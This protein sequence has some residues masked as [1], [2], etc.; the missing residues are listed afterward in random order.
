[1]SKP[2][3]P[4]TKPRPEASAANRSLDPAGRGGSGLFLTGF[5]LLSVC[6]AASGMLV[7]ESLAGLAL[8]GCGAGSPCAA[9]AASKWGKVPGINW[10]VSLVGFS[11]FVGMAHAWVVGAFDRR[12]GSL[13]IWIAR[14]GLIASLGFVVI[15]IVEKLPCVY[16][17]VCHGANAGFWIAAEL[18]AR[19]TTGKA[20]GTVRWLGAASF[21]ALAGVF[22]VA[23]AGL[24]LRWES[25]KHDV[26]AKAEQDRAAA[27]AQV[28]AAGSKPPDSKAA[29]SSKPFTGRYRWGPEKAVAR[30]VI[31]S[32][33]QCQDCKRIEG[34]VRAIMASRADVSVSAKHFPFCQ[35]CNKYAPKLHDN[36]CWAARAAEA[37]G[38]LGGDAAFWKMHAW[39]F[40]NNG[41]FANNEA[42]RPAAAAA[43]VDFDALV[44]T[45]TGEET[46]NRVKADIE[47]AWGLGMY[48][49]PMIFINGVEMKGWINGQAVARTVEQVV[50]AGLKPAGP[51][52][53][54]PPTAMEKI[55]LDWKEN[56]R[57][58]APPRARTWAKGP[59]NAPVRVLL[60][61]DYQVAQTAEADALAQSILAKRPAGSWRYEVRYFPFSRECNPAV[62]ANHPA[63][64]PMSCKS[65]RA[66][67][68]AGMLGG[69]D[70]F[71]K[72]HAWLLAN[73]DRVSDQA[74]SDA[75]PAL[76]LESAALLRAMN[77]AATS[78]AI[79]NDLAA[80]RATQVGGV[81]IFIVNDR[82]V[83]LWKMDSGEPTLDRIIEAAAAEK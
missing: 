14:L 43:G 22:A 39:L 1:M 24:G 34:E 36:A 58:P 55:V 59:E 75:A 73:R 38:I 77:D 25:V 80:A 20:G 76:G 47:E 23:L 12:I 6:I 3:A 56:P 83:R 7:L 4:K 53:D 65:A 33:Y 13:V 28:I 29:P 48:R 52:Q 46:L 16:C 17:L 18:A 51:E 67:E 69:V 9:A 21:G 64:R 41:V 26:M 70:A 30:I 71:W 61:V 74:L 79:T 42:L 63:Q 54:R 10:P 72:M 37:A 49:T 31:Y 35:D 32:D 27:A 62:A 45:M 81:P 44:R 19:R 8:P 5:V 11:Y 82:Q 78:S 57:L 15:T 60:F 40:D 66:A 50:A 2:A 68:A